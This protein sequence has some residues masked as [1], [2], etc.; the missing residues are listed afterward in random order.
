[1]SNPSGSASFFSYGTI[2]ARHVGRLERVQ[3][4]ALLV[5]EFAVDARLALVQPVLNIGLVELFVI[6][7]TS[8]GEPE[9]VAIVAKGSAHKEEVERTGILDSHESA[10]AR[11]V[12][13]S[14]LEQVADPFRTLLVQLHLLRLAF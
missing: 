8:P 2:P 5:V 3:L 4:L 11:M 7:I 9:F 1:M 12:A 10:E 14:A 13:E 6:R